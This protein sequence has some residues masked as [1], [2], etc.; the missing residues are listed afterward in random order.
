MKTKLGQS[1][2]FPNDDGL[3]YADNI[4]STPALGGTIL[5]GVALKSI[6]EI[7]VEER[8]VSIDELF[9]AD[10]VFCTENG[11]GLVP[12]SSISH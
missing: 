8:L 1:R 5:P 7:E 3:G 11:A 9:E 6:I 10:E 4:I 12:V 2:P